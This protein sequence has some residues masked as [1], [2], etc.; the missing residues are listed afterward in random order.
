M[1]CD[2]HVLYL[3]NTDCYLSNFEA[4]VIFCGRSAKRHDISQFSARANVVLFS[5]SVSTMKQQQTMLSF[6]SSNNSHEE[7]QESFTIIL[8]LN[9]T[10]LTY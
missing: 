8:G 5:Y 7:Q 1:H 9:K 10:K 3:V 4:R 2:P 6:L